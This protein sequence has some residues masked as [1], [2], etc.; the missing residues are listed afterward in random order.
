M[1]MHNKKICVCLRCGVVDVMDRLFGRLF[2]SDYD[3]CAYVCLHD[4]MDPEYV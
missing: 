4:G 3:A 2:A 1:M